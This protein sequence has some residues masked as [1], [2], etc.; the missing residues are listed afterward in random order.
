MNKF[1]ELVD[2]LIALS[3]ENRKKFNPDLI[4]MDYYC[5]EFCTIKVSCG[6]GAGKTT[7]IIDRARP[8]DIV[9]VDSE[10]RRGHGFRRC[11]APV[12]TFDELLATNPWGFR[13]GQE[14]LKPRTIYVDE[15]ITLRPDQLYRI[16]SHFSCHADQTMVV[17]G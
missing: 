7:Y 12:F 17:L 11:K 1:F 14:Q 9:V 8:W 13:R 2:A 3:L 5:M 6:R 4:G 15:G 16:W 10:L